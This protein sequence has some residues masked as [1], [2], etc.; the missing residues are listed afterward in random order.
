MLKL[1][2]SFTAVAF[3]LALG[4][5]PAVA[6]QERGGIYLVSFSGNVTRSKVS[7]GRV[8]RR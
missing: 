4:G 1:R 6:M 7:V 3:S 2:S 8:W 5:I